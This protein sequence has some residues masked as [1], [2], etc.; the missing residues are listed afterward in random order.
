MN[1]FIRRIKMKIIIILNQYRH[2]YV[3]MDRLKIIKIFIIISKFKL[4]SGK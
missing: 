1:E 3:E 4:L 2:K